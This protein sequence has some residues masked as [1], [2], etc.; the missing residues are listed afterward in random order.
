M[1]H[2]AD[3]DLLLPLLACPVDKG[4]LTHLPEEQLLY[5]P[6]LRRGYPVLDGL[7][8]LRPQD[9]VALDERRHRELLPRVEPHALGTS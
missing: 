3:L 4:P 5:N 8:R 6:R 1:S 2:S 7:P 9:A